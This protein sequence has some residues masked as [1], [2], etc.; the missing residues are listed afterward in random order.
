MPRSARSRRR[1][2]A[3]GAPLPEYAERI[4][5]TFPHRDG[6]CSERVV[7]AVLASTKRDRDTEPVP[8]PVSEVAPG[9][10]P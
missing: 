9:R 10:Q 1:W 6:G 7:Q 2:S 3:G 8:T 4:E 5:A